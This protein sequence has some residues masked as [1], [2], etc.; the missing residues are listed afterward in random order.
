MTRP[1]IDS[2]KPGTDVI[3]GLRTYLHEWE[4]QEATFLRIEGTGDDRVAWFRQ[5]DRDGKPYEW[6]AYRS[7]GHWAYGSS[8]QALR[9]N[10]VVD[11]PDTEEVRRLKFQ[12]DVLQGLVDELEAKLR[13]INAE[14][15]RL[16]A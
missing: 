12:R 16:T 14:I 5:L 6:E 9:L 11:K 15:A 1:R 2:L 10:W 13:P 8:A 7:G 3:L 4:A